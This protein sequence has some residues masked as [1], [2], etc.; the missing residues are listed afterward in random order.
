MITKVSQCSNAI[1]MNEHDK[2]VNFSYHKKI[3]EEI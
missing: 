3:E 1:N 2:F